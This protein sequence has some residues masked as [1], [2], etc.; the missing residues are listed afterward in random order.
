MV[1]NETFIRNL[2]GGIAETIPW[3]LHDFSVMSKVKFLI[4]WAQHSP[5]CRTLGLHGFYYSDS[6]SVSVEIS[7][8]GGIFGN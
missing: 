7:I 4:F 3:F 1:K 8:L 2:Q 6:Q 5:M